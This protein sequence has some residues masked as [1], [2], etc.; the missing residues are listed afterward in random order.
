MMLVKD[1]SFEKELK[2]G[3]VFLSGIR[4]LNAWVVA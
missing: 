4:T 2:N 1:I 3:I